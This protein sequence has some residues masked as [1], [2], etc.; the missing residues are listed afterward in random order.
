VKYFLKGDGGIISIYRLFSGLTFKLEVRKII[1]KDKKMNYFRPASRSGVIIISLLS[2]LIC[3]ATVVWAQPGRITTVVTG[4]E[5]MADDYGLVVKT[6]HGN[7]IY[8]QDKSSKKM[9]ALLNES[10]D[11]KRPIIIVN[12]PRYI[13]DV[14]AVTAS[15]AESASRPGEMTLVE[16][17]NARYLIPSSPEEWIQLH[18]GNYSRRN[19]DN[20]LFVVLEK[21]AWGQLGQEG[22]KK[23]A[24]IYSFNGGGSGVFKI[25]GI[26]QS[27]QGKP[28]QLAWEEL[29]DRVIIESMA[30]ESGK[31]VVQMVTHGPDDPSCCPTLKKT[32]VFSLMGNKLVEQ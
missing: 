12:G 17:K 22:D 28:Q 7:F 8:Y 10:L 18:N 5:P 26:M 1:K 24:V 16:I 29:G 23:A 4:F 19:P 25:L 11:K 6:T 32:A 31:V 20:P 15:A 9:D 27:L 14:L 13:Q 21:V 30:V 2:F 3:M